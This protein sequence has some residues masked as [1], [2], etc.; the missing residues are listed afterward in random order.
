MFKNILLSGSTGF[1][2]KIIKE[3]LSNAYE[4]K[5]IGRIDSDYLFDFSI[6]N[7]LILKENFDIIIHCAGKAHSIPK[8]EKE[9]EEFYEIN[10]EGTKRFLATIKASNKL[11]KAFVFISTVAV[12]GLESGNDIDEIYPLIATDPYGKSKILAEK[13]VEQWCLNNGVKCTILRLPLIVGKNPK[14]N[15]TSMIKGIEKGYY[16]NIGGGIAKKSMVLAD[17]VANFIPKIAEI[18][19]IYNLTDN[20]HPSFYE[21][22]N[23]IALN[24]NKPKPRNLP[25]SIVVILAKIG[26]ILGDKFPINSNK[27]KKIISDL[28]FS[29][30]LASKTGLWIPKKVIEYF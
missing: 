27:L 20:C 8:T 9:K 10:F 28:T 23:K 3:S 15:L 25:Y 2:G 21:L 7:T 24:L 29:D 14:G 18:G 17:D 6:S 11:P 30:S 22:S 4:I 13:E 1:L 19:G 12:Y 5:T 16:F 26:D